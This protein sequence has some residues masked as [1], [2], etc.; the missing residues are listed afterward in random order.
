[1][2][3][4]TPYD[5]RY[6]HMTP[7]VRRTYTTYTTYTILYPIYKSWDEVEGRLSRDMAVQEVQDRASVASEVL[8]GASSHHLLPLVVGVGI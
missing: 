4:C 7:Y 5:T 2:T 8:D 6:T 3:R 1:M